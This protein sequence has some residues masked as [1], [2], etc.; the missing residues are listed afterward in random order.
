MLD[1]AWLMLVFPALGALII[2]LFGTRLGRRVV[3]FLAPA[4]VFLS[5]AVAVALAIQLFSLPH[6]EQSH[7]V[8]L[9]QWMAAGNFSVDA[10]L[11]IDPLSIVM[12]LVVTGVGFLIHVYSTGYMHDDP[13]FPRFFAYLNL[14][15]LMMLTLVLADN[16]LL[17]FVGWEGVGLASYLL[18]GFWFE[19]PSAADAG[20]KAFIVN[21]IGDFGLLLAI[22]VIWTGLGS[23]RFTEVFEAAPEVW[24]VGNIAVMTATMLMLLAATGKSAQI[25]LYVWLPDAMEGPTPV[26]ALIHAATMVTAGVYMIA[27]SAPLFDLAPTTGNWVAWI[28]VATALIAGTIAL[29]QTDMKRILAYSTVSQLG[30]MF[31]AVGVG[32]YA[33]GIF[34]LITHAFFKALLF[35]GAGSVMHGLHGELDIRKMGNL[36]AKMPITHWTFFIGAGALA[37]VPLLSGFFSKDAIL[38]NA[39]N[40]SI[41]L[42]AIGAVTAFITAVYSFRMVFMAFWG[43]ERDAKLWSHAHESPRVM[44]IPLILLAVGALLTGYLGLPSLS[45]IDPALEPAFEAAA[46]ASEGHANLTLELIL[47]VVSGLIALAGVFLAY[48]AFLV[49]KDLPA[50][51]RA[52]LG[53][54]T[55]LVDNKYYVDELYNMIIVNPLRSFGGWL[56][57]TFDKGGIDGAVNGLAGVTGWLGT[58][59]R[60]LQTGMVG[61]YALAMLFGAVALL[62]WLAIR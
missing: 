50:R 60:R 31:V 20:K 13:R 39:F 32:A 28:G 26:S 17:M 23:L 40:Y 10:G 7:S 8:L 29:T 5:F 33:A 61:L 58:Q 21:R 45:L 12:A 4:M 46:G 57:A 59:V 14:F 34:H 44:T 3:G 2:S 48:R 41:P 30:F 25:P 56:A 22:M 43:K 47:L 42:W 37:G 55:K 54:V 38:Y 36:R 6:E 16:Y 51:V 9:W 1:Y 27:R 52:A 35:L 49:N 19:K 24:G 18:I 53:P 11:L 15:I 62:A